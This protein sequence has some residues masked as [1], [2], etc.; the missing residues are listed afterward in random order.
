MRSIFRSGLGLV[1]ILAIAGC[2]TILKGTSQIVSI[3]SNVKG[4][5]VIVNGKNVGVT[6]F[7]GQI[8]RKSGTTVIV[9]KAGYDTKTFTMTT[10]IESVFWGNIIIGGVLGSTTDLATGAMYYYAPATLQIDLEK[11]GAEEA[12][13]EEPAAKVPAGKVPAGAPKKGN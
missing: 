10:E 12:E 5:T 4:A 2:A 11:T 9:Q 7:N 6:P 8:E 13:S 3:N 1:A